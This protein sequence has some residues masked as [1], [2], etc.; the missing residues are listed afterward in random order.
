MMTL[1]YSFLIRL[2]SFF[3]FGVMSG[4]LTG[5]ATTITDFSQKSLKD[6]DTSGILFGHVDVEYNGKT[7]NSRCAVC[8]T[9]AES[10]CYKLPRSGNIL[11]KVTA[12]EM[13]LKRVSC[14]DTVEYHTF[15]KNLTFKTLPQQR[16]YFGNVSVRWT[17]PKTG[18]QWDKFFDLMGAAVNDKKED[19]TSTVRIEDNMKPVLAQLEPLFKAN[20]A[21]PINVCMIG[22]AE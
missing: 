22:Q 21:L 10:G 4:L 9:G 12:G 8:F 1:R 19:G 7:N 14:L 5:C 13:T 20:D 15:P 17:N 11:M 2:L 16:N 6:D 3:V 18:F